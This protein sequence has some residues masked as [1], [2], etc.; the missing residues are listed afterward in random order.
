MLLA[1]GREMETPAEREV[2]RTEA[3]TWMVRTW[4]EAPTRQPRRTRK[5]RQAE[6]QDATEEQEH[7]QVQ[8]Q[9]Q[10]QAQEQEQ[11][12]EEVGLWRKLPSLLLRRQ[13]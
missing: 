5:E 12:Q 1:V 3:C 4:M 8:M 9:T 7:A 6:E 2:A 13:S 11:E 10:D